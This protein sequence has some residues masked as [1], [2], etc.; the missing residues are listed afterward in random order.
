MIPIKDKYKTVFLQIF[1]V[2]FF[3]FLFSDYCSEIIKFRYLPP[4]IA[5]LYPCF[6]LL[7]ETQT[8]RNFF[9]YNLHKYHEP[10]SSWPTWRFESCLETEL[11]SVSYLNNFRW[12]HFVICLHTKDVLHH[13]LRNEFC[14][15]WLNIW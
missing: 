4:N 3:L 7:S 10:Q 8:M 14:Y 6:G 2:D 13:C 12:L 11:S 9:P 5:K 1:P 15:I